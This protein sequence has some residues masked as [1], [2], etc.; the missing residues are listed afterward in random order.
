MA[1]CSFGSMTSCTLKILSP[2]VERRAEKGRLTAD[3]DIDS[4]PSEGAGSPESRITLSSSNFSA[5]GRS[6]NG[7]RLV[8]YHVPATA[9]SDCGQT[10]DQNSG[11]CTYR[12]LMLVD[13]D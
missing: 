3:A 4:V 1:G 11:L 2:K 9:C 7:R 10:M 8:I 5:F 13:G 6:A 12:L